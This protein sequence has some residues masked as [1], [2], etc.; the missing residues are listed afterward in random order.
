MSD[1]GGAQDQGT[2]MRAAGSARPR[3]E[4]IAMTTFEAAAHERAVR[5]TPPLPPEPGER[6]S[7]IEVAAPVPQGVTP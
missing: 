6:P 4:V 7:S 1:S 2:A 3:E 5:T